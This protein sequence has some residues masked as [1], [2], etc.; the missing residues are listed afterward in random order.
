MSSSGSNLVASSSFTT[1]PDEQ[2]QKQDMCPICKTDRYLSPDMRFLI[3]PECYHK[4]CESCVDRIY[5]LGPAPCPYPGCG[6]TLRKNKFKLQVFDDVLVEKEIDIRGRVLAIYNKRELDFA[7]LQHFNAYLEEVESIIDKL[8]NN[9]DLEETERMI[10]EYKATNSKAISQNNQ[11]REK[12]FEDFKKREQM[13]KDVKLKKV[14]LE[15]QIEEEE[16][17]LNEM[18]RKEILSKLATSQ[19]A[20]Q[21]I[22]QVKASVLKK[23]S[24]RRRQLKEM[25]KSLSASPQASDESSK[26]R[27]TPFTP[28]NGDR[29]TK[30]T[31]H[32]KESYYDPFIE[33]LRGRKEYI[34][35]GFKTE[36]V[37]ERIL[38]EA[39]LGLGCFI[40][41]ERPVA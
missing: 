39:F 24:A 2:S 19:D 7:D 20:N 10:S 18:A 22:S 30:K 35:S 26:K 14:Q 8:M 40:D 17:E 33:D 5:S 23:T 21:I 11:S 36:I 38:S 31:Y 25:M 15:K 1:F 41:R 27:T 16:R 37:Y 3:N 4:M 12:E 34:A 28:F 32:L 6:K 9:V 13:E 29:V